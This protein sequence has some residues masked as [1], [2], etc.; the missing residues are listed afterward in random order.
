MK[1][2]SGFALL[3]LA[4]T[5]VVVQPA[6]GRAHKSFEGIELY[7]WKGPA[8]NWCF[9]LLP[10]TNRLKTVTEIKKKKNKISSVLELR[11]K[12]L[13]L[14]EGEQIFWS[15]PDSGGFTF[16]DEKT[17]SEIMDAAKKADVELHLLSDNSSTK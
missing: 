5:A 14:A 17:K 15:S 4:M 3:L 11:K 12:F 13:K 7:S 8:E 16:P 2:I 1:L 9:A 6:F 10:G